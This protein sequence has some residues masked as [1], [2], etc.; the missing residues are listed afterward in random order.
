MNGTRRSGDELAWE[1]DDA[2]FALCRRE[3]YTAV[4]GDVMDARGHRH[5]FLPPRVRPLDDGMVL[6]GRAMPVLQADCFAERAESGANP[7]MDAPFGLMLEA[8]DDLRPQEV[9]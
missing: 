3:L 9:Y 6:V 8:L 7:V 5:Q 2:L 1:D 4:V